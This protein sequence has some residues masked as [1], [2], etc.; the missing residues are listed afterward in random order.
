MFLAGKTLEAYRA[1]PNDAAVA[2]RRLGDRLVNA[3]NTELLE[4]L[5]AAHAERLPDDA[6]LP[7][8][9][10]RLLLPAKKLARRPHCL[11]RW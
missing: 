11:S 4:Q 6:W 5:I 7:Y 2:F 9:R 1:V 8:Y 10:G 3:T